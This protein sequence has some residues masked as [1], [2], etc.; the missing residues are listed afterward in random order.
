MKSSNISEFGTTLPPSGNC[1]VMS[2]TESA[3]DEF[4][5]LIMQY[6]KISDP[7]CDWSR[8]NFSGYSIGKLRECV[9]DVRKFSL[10]FTRTECADINKQTVDMQAIEFEIRRR[11][12]EEQYPEIWGPL[13]HANETLDCIADS[14]KELSGWQN[15]FDKHLEPVFTNLALE[16][17]RK[18]NL[19]HRYVNVFENDVGLTKIG[20]NNQKILKL[21]DS[22]TT[23][24]QIFFI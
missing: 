2:R 20:G 8:F 12:F 17:L 10:G 19:A 4:R 11:P 14:H 21:M 22:Y 18:H 3:I 5:A 16:Y 15:N 1:A 24:L 7:G 13:K 23:K 6:F 9:N